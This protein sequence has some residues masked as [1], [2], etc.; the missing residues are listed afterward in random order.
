M[1]FY[2]EL[3]FHRVPVCY[4]LILKYK[5]KVV[6]SPGT[7]VYYII[8]AS[9]RLKMARNAGDCSICAWKYIISQVVK[10]RSTLEAVL[11]MALAVDYQPHAMRSVGNEV[12]GP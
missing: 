8:T 1:E 5:I 11:L 7:S 9:P 10:L 3:K 4:F 6:F 12:P 2:Y